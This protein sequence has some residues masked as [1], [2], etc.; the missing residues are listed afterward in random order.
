MNFLL[1]SAQPVVPDQP[2]SH[3]LSAD[4]RPDSKAPTTLEGLIADHTFL[5]P[6]NGDRDNGVGGQ[7]GGI[8]VS[9]AKNEVP[10][11][12]N[13]SDVT[14]LEGWITIPCKELPENWRDAPDILT[15]R[16]LD[17]SFVFPGEQVHILACLSASKKDMEII[18]PF[19]VAAVMS[20]N[21]SLGHDPKQKDENTGNDSNSVADQGTGSSMHL[22]AVSEN[23]EQNGENLSTKETVDIQ[24][25][26]TASESL[27]RMENH[28]KRTEAQLER[29]RNSHFFVRI[30][31]SD[32]PLWSKRSVRDSSSATS[33]L[34][35]D[36]FTT[37]EA[38]A[39]ID[40][41]SFDAS[42]SGGVARNA[43]KC[44]A[45][46]NG[47]IVMLLQV[48]VGMHFL[49]DPILEVL[50]FEKYQDRNQN[51]ANSENLVHLNDPC[52]E[53]LKWLLP[54]DRT[55]LPPVRPLSPPP[56]SSSLGIGSASQKS[57]FSSSSGSHLF[58]FGNFRSYSMS[59]LPQNST[60]PPA[61]TTSNSRPNFD[62]D[63]WDRLSPQKSLDGPEAG[64]AGLLSFRGVSLEPDRFSVHCGLEG[65]YIPGRRWRKKVEVIQPVEI[66]SFAAECNT[67][68]LLCVQI[69][70][71]CPPHIPDIVIYLD[72]IAIV[73]EE[74]PKGGPPVS[75]PIT[76]VEA[77]NDYTLPN[78]PLRLVSFYIRNEEHSFILKPA[79]SMW[80]SN[81]VHSGRSLQQS[82]SK[83]RSAVP[84]LYLPSKIAEG[85]RISSADQYAVLVSCRCNYTESRLFF[86]QPT[87]WRPRFTRDLMISVASEMSEQSLG[88]SGGL[89]Q[90]PVQV[91]T[92]QAS[93]LTSEDLTLTVLAPA[94][95]TS[96]PSV[97]S[98]NSAPSTP[99]SPFVGFSEFAGRVSGER[100]STGM[101]RPSSMPRVS[102][103]QKEKVG[104]ARSVSF[105]EQTVS[106][107]DVVPTSGLGCTH[108][109]LQ[110][111]VPLGCVP[112]Q[113]TATVKLELLPLTDGIITLDTLQVNVKEKG[114]H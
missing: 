20:K 17:R 44:Y 83:S 110:S 22:S 78:M 72:A 36:N 15:F 85:K 102:E 66:H 34:V 43:V 29:F 39:Y 92:L 69:K 109:W 23:A 9:S 55:L 4:F 49:N 64:N 77:G 30:A 97:V 13:H 58:S 114:M 113:S 32:E 6:E 26:I 79:T 45:L 40:R 57:S 46:S 11:V 14:E 7:S 54:L 24:A 61:I 108:L 93:N 81:K 48:N 50:Q 51:L 90:L 107:S 71:V 105:D 73:F 33:N 74:A 3:D 89:T 87:S 28:K 99:M 103:N 5:Q 35:R 2:T 25:D 76:C 21:G 95:L 37:T 75:L 56:L 86:K 101:H 52:G 106:I 94:S 60:P 59:S 31:E 84:N 63:E 104:G 53:L 1:R 62:L 70:N 8:G 68:D 67:E 27:V 12:G 91:L 65:I 42:V 16:A 18:T 38:N 98:L 80:S 111:A 88:P 47:D 41:G 82:H 100:R 96:P 19:K 10:V 112:S